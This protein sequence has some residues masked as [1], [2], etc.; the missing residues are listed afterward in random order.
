MGHGSLAQ[1][2]T[3]AIAM[4]CAGLSPTLPYHRRTPAGGIALAI[5]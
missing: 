1:G 4:R 3:H 5:T 2:W